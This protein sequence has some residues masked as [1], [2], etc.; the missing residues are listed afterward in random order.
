MSRISILTRGTVGGVALLACFVAPATF[1]A[2][3]TP[4]LKP[5]EKTKPE[6]TLEARVAAMEKRVQ[7]LEKQLAERSAAVP[8]TE[9]TPRSKRD[10]GRDMDEMWNRFRRELE[11]GLGEMPEM[12]F[13]P[14]GMMPAQRPRLGVQMAEIT[15]EFVERFK[16]D[17]KEGVF[18][19][20]V[21]PGSPA[22][23]AGLMAGDAVISFA[24][25]KITNAEDLLNAV[26]N[27]PKGKSEA[28]VMRRNQELKLSVDLGSPEESDAAMP[29]PLR[30]DGGWLRR[31]DADRQP[32]GLGARKRTRTE[33]RGEMSTPETED[34]QAKT[35]F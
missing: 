1:G 32:G 34:E 26:K 2:D 30:P 4:V 20:S 10:I 6:A 29:D 31:G 12:R 11:Q 23:K 18:I 7:Y 9:H 16:N 8:R 25:K 27:A 5:D 17:V 28:I 3:D 22:E 13:G 33:I 21:V 24:T 19:M 15:P 14:P 35:G